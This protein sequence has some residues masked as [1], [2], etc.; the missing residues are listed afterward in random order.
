MLNNANNM[1]MELLSNPKKVIR[2]QE[3]RNNALI[4]ATKTLASISKSLKEPSISYVVEYERPQLIQEHIPVMIANDEEDV[5][6]VDN[7]IINTRL[8]KHNLYQ[9]FFTN[10]KLELAAT[11]NNS[12]LY[13]DHLN[14]SSTIGSEQWNAFSSKTD[15]ISRGCKDSSMQ[16]SVNSMKYQDK[17]IIMGLTTEFITNNFLVDKS[18][19]FHFV[20][21]SFNLFR[22]TIKKALNLEGKIKLE[23]IFKGGN[24]MKFLFESL[25]KK[26][27]FEIV[28][29]ITEHYGEYFKSSDFDFDFPIKPEIEMSD[30][31]YN[32][33]RAKILNIMSLFMIK[34]KDII[35]KN[36]LYF[37]DFFNQN[38][39]IQTQKMQELSKNILEKGIQKIIE[40]D[41]EQYTDK[42]IPKRDYQWLEGAQVES[43]IFD[44]DPITRMYKYYNVANN[45]IQESILSDVINVTD[46]FVVNDT[47][48]NNKAVFESKTY[49]INSKKFFNN[50]LQVADINK[51][52]YD[53]NNNNFIFHSNNTNL[54]FN[55]LNNMI[56]AFSLLRLKYNFEVRFKLADGTIFKSKFPGE[57]LDI[58]S[59]KLYDFKFL[60]S[61][62]EYY[63]II[64]LRDININLKTQSY[65][66][67][68]VELMN[69]LF[70]ET[71]Y[72]PWEDAKYIKR[73][74]RLNLLL[75]L[76]VLT[77][78]EPSELV[79]IKLIEKMLNNIHHNLNNPTQLI[80]FMPEPKEDYLYNNYF[81][82]YYNYLI[83]TTKNIKGNKD[84]F[85]EFKK[86]VEEI[87]N[88]C[89]K[90]LRTQYMYSKKEEIETYMGFQ[91]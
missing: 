20:V 49:I 87:I 42:I 77:L 17:Q 43:I 56:N 72:S 36:R 67:L 85:K 70:N 38:I 88:D 73:L 75:F 16:S 55:V 28:K 21:S 33:Y 4:L 11:L 15:A 10:N 12:I 46:F 89:L 19:Y 48:P 79:K 78:S 62:S 86:T 41:I 83:G 59:P 30:E 50:I 27:N 45:A 80:E 71:Q 54:Q 8:N 35:I 24:L 6:F 63:K 76:R 69:I 47:V 25:N 68:I 29:W 61:K 84:N 26:L 91:D 5:D 82:I 58:S 44:F 13:S 14:H 9:Q 1:I 7:Q 52:M 23:L 66:G 40:K 18:K 37:F 64:R 65:Q 34:L 57:L 39:T 74:K 3:D 31:I 90:I 60:S 2:D 51:N 53:M 22:K 81:K 32:D